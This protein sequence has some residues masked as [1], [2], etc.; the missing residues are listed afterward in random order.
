MLFLIEI[1]V[2]CDVKCDYNIKKIKYCNVIQR[3]FNKY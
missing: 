1:N 2:V 3:N